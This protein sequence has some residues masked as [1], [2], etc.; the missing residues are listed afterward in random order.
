[1]MSRQNYSKLTAFLPIFGCMMLSAQIVAAAPEVTTKN[2][3]FNVLGSTDVEIR[4][5]LETHSGMDAY[6]GN[7]FWA[8]SVWSTKW[9]I[10]W[11]ETEDGCVLS[12]VD[13][14]V[15]VENWIPRWRNKR[16]ATPE[17]RARLRRTSAAID[18]YWQQT[19]SN[20]VKAAA[21]IE[22]LYTRFPSFKTCKELSTTF[23]AQGNRISELY[24][25]RRKAVEKRT[26]NGTRQVPD[27]SE[28]AGV[29]TPVPGSPDLELDGWCQISDDMETVQTLMCRY[30][31]SCE[32]DSERCRIDFSWP[33]ERIQ[34]RYFN[35]GP[36]QWN[37][38]LADFAFINK[39]PCVR[40]VSDD[41]ILC[42]SEDEP[43]ERWF[44]HLP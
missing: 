30:D 23:H 27:L 35:G 1:M 13:A 7:F 25:D 29:E 38:E 14:A 32:P 24:R 26:G 3:Y 44:Y 6:W 28:P 18:L 31:R 10:G 5:Y 39:T 16:D 15:E 33:E 34:V 20:G 40:R 37:D 19:M 43:T 9:N 11:R 17:L 21:E 12:S 36:V 22:K 2:S 41:R 42:F 8:K 4:I